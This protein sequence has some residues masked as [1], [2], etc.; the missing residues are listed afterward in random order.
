MEAVESDQPR[1]NLVILTLADAARLGPALTEAS[2][3][4]APVL[5]LLASGDRG[6]LTRALSEG[7]ADAMLAPVH[8]PELEARLT[9]RLA[10]AGFAGTRMEAAVFDIVQEVWASARAEEVLRA[11]VRRVGRALD[12]SHCSFILTRPGRD[13][14]RVVAEYDRPTVH[15]LRLDLQR[16]PEVLEAVRTSEPVVVP[17]VEVHPLFEEIRRQWAEEQLEVPIRSVVALPVR[18]DGEVVAV[19]L[20]RPRAPGATLTPA[21][22]HFA[23]GLASGAAGLLLGGARP[24]R[25]E[26]G[27]ETVDPLTGCASPRAL[28]QRVAEEFARAHRYAL[29]FSLVLLDVERLG[30][31]NQRLGPEA[32]DRLLAELGAVLQQELRRPDYVARYGDDEFALVLPETGTEG[33]RRSLDRVRRRLEGDRFRQLAPDGSPG[34]VAGIATYPHPA[35]L[36]PDDLLALAEAALLRGKG[37]M[38]DRVGTAEGVSR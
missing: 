5:V 23:E 7:A 24:G 22:I 20:L 26:A 18:A 19:F 2:G 29:T 1:P 17:D 9:A 13:F 3:I 8:L 31:L 16:Y 21:Q 30:E 6:D 15:D 34:V 36:E 27:T 4:G 37:Q 38:E 10:P 12:L 25:H 35:A 14:G 28:E 11:L 32:G 33:A